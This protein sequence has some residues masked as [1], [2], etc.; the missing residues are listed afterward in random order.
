ML[1]GEES[2]RP[3]PG[4]VSA[5]EIVGAA[6]SEVED[7]K[8]IKVAMTRNLSVPGDVAPDLIHVISELFENA[9]AY[10]PASEPVSVVSSLTADRQWR[11]DITDRGAGNARRPR[12]AGANERLGRRRV[13]VATGSVAAAPFPGMRP[14]AALYRPRHR[15]RRLRVLCANQTTHARCHGTV[16][17]RR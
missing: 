10:S 8:R 15:P 14:A 2:A 9:T 12:S 16:A 4:S 13:R 11:I 1:A 7:Y 3:L 6:L 17:A 5:D